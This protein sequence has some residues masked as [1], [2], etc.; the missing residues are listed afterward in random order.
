MAHLLLKTSQFFACYSSHAYLKTGVLHPTAP[1]GLPVPAPHVQQAPSELLRHS[2]VHTSSSATHTPYTLRGHQCSFNSSTDAGE[3]HLHEE[4]CLHVKVLGRFESHS[5]WSS[6]ATAIPILRV[7]ASI[8]P[9]CLAG[10]SSS[11]QVSPSASPIPE[12]FH[13]NLSQHPTGA[14]SWRAM[15]KRFILHTVI[16]SL[17]LN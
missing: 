1:C 2:S 13:L 12:I 8:F 15:A 4:T 3:A 14:P 16:S 6:F 5:S 7:T 10:P 9:S 11:L 17:S